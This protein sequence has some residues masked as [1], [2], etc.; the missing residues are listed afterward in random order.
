MANCDYAESYGMFL[1]GWNAY[2]SH[3][4]YLEPDDSCYSDLAL[5]FGIRSKA[6]TVEE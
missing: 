1:S 6:L 4:V 2:A 5:S 3:A